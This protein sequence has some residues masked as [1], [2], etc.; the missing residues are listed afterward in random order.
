[1]LLP[2]L[3][4]PD[5]PDNQVLSRFTYLSPDKAI[6]PT[7][8][9]R[10]QVRWSQVVIPRLVRKAE[11]ETYFSPYHLTPLKGSA[12]VVTTLHDFCHMHDSPFTMGGAVHRSFMFSALV[13]ADR[14]ICVSQFTMDQMRSRFP[15]RARQAQV[16]WNGI[17]NRPLG[18]DE[19][20]QIVSRFGIEGDY[21]IWIGYPNARKNPALVAETAASLDL[22]LV[23]VMPP[24]STLP[25]ARY[26]LSGVSGAERDALLRCARCLL[27]PS[28]CEGFGFPVAEAMRQ[29]CPPLGL[30]GTVVEELTGDLIKHPSPAR[31]VETARRVAYE[32]REL[33]ARLIERS[34][35]FSVQ[36]TA[37][38]TWEVVVGSSAR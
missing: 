17:A 15:R 37:A 9:V 34:A 20:R 14:Y 1:L 38:K 12:R 21:V 35:L 30:S 4:R 7:A 6:D 26:S 28:I 19:A 16:V 31:Y 36:G 8:S 33:E 23:T 11:V 22:P 32:G 29:G 25:N 24:G 27:F 5:S 10:E 13:G 2:V 18:L 3:P